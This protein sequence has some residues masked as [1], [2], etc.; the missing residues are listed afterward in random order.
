MTTPIFIA[1]ALNEHKRQANCVLVCE[2]QN[3][4][5]QIRGRVVNGNWYAHFDKEGNGLGK[6]KGTKIM[7][8]GK[9]PDHISS[10]NHMI[11]WFV[12]EIMPGLLQPLPEPV[13]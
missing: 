4:I 2:R 7:W 12:E 13:P 6:A 11:T 9:Q 3:A 10:Y 8:S 5:G 1:V